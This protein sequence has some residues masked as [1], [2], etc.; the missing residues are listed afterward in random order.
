M[1]SNLLIQL[2]DVNFSFKG[3]DILKDISLKVS[4]EEIVTIIGPN[5]AGKTTLFRIILGLI[6]PTSGSLWKAPDLKIGYMPQKLHI[7]QTLP[8]TVKRFL[9][10]K[11]K[12]TQI[13]LIDSLA[14]VRASSLIDRSLHVLSG[15][16]MQRVLLARAIM[17]KP[18]LLVLD[19]PV[20][21]VDINGQQ[22]LYQFIGNLRTKLNCGI[23][24][25]S[26]DLH[27]VLASSDQVI[28]LNQHVCCAGQPEKVILDPEYTALFGTRAAEHLALYTH[29]H[30]HV[31][32]PTDE[33]HSHG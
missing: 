27:L 6:K 10:L 1:T 24:L 5:G 20:Q 13:E 31:H 26:H 2:N 18:D 29:H 14:A 32:G 28:C 17:G 19:E 30:D 12:V 22:E 7:E 8:I 16:E 15:G 3:Q 25:V 23:L 21:G 11:A 4:R 33:G 9:S